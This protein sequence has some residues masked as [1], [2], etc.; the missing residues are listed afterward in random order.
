MCGKMEG[1]AANMLQRQGRVLG[2]AAE[3]R[4][5]CLVLGA[6]LNSRGKGS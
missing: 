6:W 1:T 3:P 5:W 2:A 4:A